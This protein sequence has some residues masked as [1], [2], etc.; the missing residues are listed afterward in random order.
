[1]PGKTLALS[2]LFSSCTVQQ[3]QQAADL[4]PDDS[5]LTSEDVAE[6]LKEALI[7]GVT[8]GSSEVSK[9]NGYLKNPKIR[10]PF[11]PNTAN[12]A[13]KL[14]SIGMGKEVNT[15]VSTLNRGAEEAAK[16]AAPIFI[17]AIRSMTMEDAWAILKGDDPTGATD[18]LKRTTSD[19]L[20][21]KFAPVMG[22]ALDRTVATKYYEELISAY[23][24]IPLV[25]K[26]D[27]DLEGY[28]T[29]KAMDGLFF[30]I[31][32]EERKIRKDPAARTTEL[33]RRVFVEQDN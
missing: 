23:N 33:L 21:E 5:K 19:Q 20:R 4:Y 14:H 8:K 12:V 13:S 16:E 6:G 1:M 30:M 26:A 31:A 24:K 9:T 10:I 15:F 7:T 2:V 32:R 18:Y 27:P 11:P 28:A 29:Q 3:I 17:S 25:K 22:R